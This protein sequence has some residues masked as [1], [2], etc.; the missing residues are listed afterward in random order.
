MQKEWRE[1]MKDEKKKTQKQDLSVT[2]KSLTNYSKDYS[3]LIADI[4][5]LIDSTE[6]MATLYYKSQLKNA[7]NKKLKE[8]YKNDK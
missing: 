8:V 3:K 5:N 4:N 6:G 1:D 2:A 7:I